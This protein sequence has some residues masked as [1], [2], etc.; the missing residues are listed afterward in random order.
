MTSKEYID[1]GIL[2]TYVMGAASHS[3][4]EEVEKMAATYPAIRQEI[5]AISGAL[6]S[7]A[8]EYALAP[9]PSVKPLL[10]ATIDYSERI[11]SG[12]AISFPPILT[13]NSRV[14]DYAP[15]LNRPDLDFT[16]SDDQNLFARLIGYTKKMTT[17]IVWI[18]EN[19]PRE[20][21]HHELES[22]L[23]IEG[24]C[25][26]YVGDKSNHLV[27]GD[28]FTIP[29]HEYHMVKV[30]SDIACKAILQRIAA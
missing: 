3:E 29:L 9:S 7:Y 28:Y 10:M 24:T 11:Q 16:G 13:E 6:E 5:D 14:A 1:S 19:S 20:I 18:K 23:I 17:A 27:A 4:Q 2:E 26:I 8:M 15:W 22:F 21:H 12:E 30:T 25:D